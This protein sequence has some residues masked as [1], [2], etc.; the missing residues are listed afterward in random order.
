VVWYYL[1]VAGDGHKESPQAAIIAK[2]HSDHMVNLMVIGED[3]TPR[4]DTSVPL[5]QDNNQEVPATCYCTWMPYQ[6]GQAAKAEEL[7]KRLTQDFGG[8]PKTPAA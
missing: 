4:G 5:I 3:G 6:K 7:E 2:V 1:Y 8:A